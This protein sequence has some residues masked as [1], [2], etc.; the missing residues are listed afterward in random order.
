LLRFEPPET[1]L[2]FAFEADLRHFLEYAPLLMSKPE[3]VAQYGQRSIDGRTREQ[4]R[5][6]LAIRSSIR[7]RRDAMCLVLADAFGGDVRQQR[8]SAERRLQ[9]LDDAAICG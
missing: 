5:A 3:Q 8:V 1:C 6:P 7:D 2:R 9:V 4:H